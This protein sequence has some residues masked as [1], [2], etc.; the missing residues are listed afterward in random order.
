MDRPPIYIICFTLT[1]TLTVLMVSSARYLDFHISIMGDASKKSTKFGS[2]TPFAEPSWWGPFSLAFVQ[3]AALA[4]S[5]C[6]PIESF[7]V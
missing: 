2:Q 5:A 1:L 4:C 6:T 3:R 7:G